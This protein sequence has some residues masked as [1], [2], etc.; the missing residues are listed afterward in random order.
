[1]KLISTLMVTSALMFSACATT[2]GVTNGLSGALTNSAKKAAKKAAVDAAVEAV[3]GPAAVAP[4]QNIAP[5]QQAV[6]SVPTGDAAKTCEQIKS[7]I[8]ETDT[9]F[10]TAEVASGRTI[11]GD[12]TNAAVSYGM[13]KAVTSG[14]LAKVPFGG[15]FAKRAVK[16]KAKA[17][18]KKRAEAELAMQNANMRKSTLMGV[19]AGKGCS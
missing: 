3:A 4:A 11:E 12:V 16:A 2:S 13:S 9:V 14:A 19:Y 5:V 18:A 8:A 17:E 1:M 10:A 15:M 6:V 7:E